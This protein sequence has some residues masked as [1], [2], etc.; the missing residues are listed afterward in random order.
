MNGYLAEYSLNIHSNSQ[1]YYNQSSNSHSNKNNSDFITVVVLAIILRKDNSKDNGKNKKLC[2][3]PRCLCN[4]YK[5]M[6]LPTM[7]PRVGYDS[8]LSPHRTWGW[9]CGHGSS[10]LKGLGHLGFYFMI[11]VA[12][13]QCPNHDQ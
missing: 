1:C 6:W 5:P 2:L 11:N 8:V 4:A 12:Y 13:F 7:W 10:R 9:R 3:R